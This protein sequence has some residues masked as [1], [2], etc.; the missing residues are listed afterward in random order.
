MIY[1]DPTGAIAALDEICTPVKR[2]GG[3]ISGTGTTNIETLCDHY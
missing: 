1:K 2:G 3:D